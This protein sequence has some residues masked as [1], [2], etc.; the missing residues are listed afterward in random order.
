MLLN[1]SRRWIWLDTLLLHYSHAFTRLVFTTRRA[2]RV[3]FLTIHFQ[4]S[5]LFFFLLFEPKWSQVFQIQYY[6]TFPPST[7]IR[8]EFGSECSAIAIKSYSSFEDKLFL[9]SY[10]FCAVLCMKMKW[11][12]QLTSWGRTAQW[13]YCFR[14][15]PFSFG[16]HLIVS[17][18]T[19]EKMLCPVFFYIAR[20]VFS[21]P[22]FAC[23]FVS[24]RVQ[25]DTTA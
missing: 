2:S 13:I 11:N 3:H 23:W 19:N 16:K 8:T 18:P 25:N 21:L 9:I 10:W 6:F 4:L 14:C 24:N 5:A 22:S 7:S 20:C 12:L 15:T 1:I 17:I